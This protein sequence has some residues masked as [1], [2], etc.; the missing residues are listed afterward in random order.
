MKFLLRLALFIV[1]TFAFAAD[2]PDLGNNLAYLRVHALTDA[3][4]DLKATLPL[5]HACVLDVRYATATN[6][7]IDALKAALAGHPA[8]EPLF[9]LVGASTPAAIVDALALPTHPKFIT[10]GITGTQPAPRIEVRAT[11]ETDRAAY[12]AYDH[13]KALTELVTGKVEKERYDESTLVHEFKNGNPD[14]E[15]ALSPDAP[16]S[17]SDK[18]DD[19]GDTPEPIR[20]RVLQRALNL[21]QALLALRR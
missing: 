11:A 2:A 21:H 20:D 17:K 10:L 1:P 18:S 7:A 16:K 5:K 9:I 8:D 15:A 12:D 14:P 4:G 19:S 13:G 3:A 6:E